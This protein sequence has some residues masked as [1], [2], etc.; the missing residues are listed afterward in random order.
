MFCHFFVLLWSR[1][2][3]VSQTRHT[4]FGTSPLLTSVSLDNPLRKWPWHPC[5]PLFV[6]WWYQR[7]RDDQIFLSLRRYT[8]HTI[9]PSYNSLLS[10]PWKG[11]NRPLC[12]AIINS[13]SLE[14]RINVFIHVW[15]K[16]C[17]TFLTYSFFKC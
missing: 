5:D 1:I 11:S 6:Y 3:S 15:V 13:I 14:D 10:I 12:I 17:D 9:V 7:V 8:L 16:L 2:N 4:S